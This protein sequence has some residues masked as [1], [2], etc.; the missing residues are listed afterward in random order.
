MPA[1]LEML[2]E[3]ILDGARRAQQSGAL[4]TFDLP[5]D[6]PINRPKRP[7]WGDFSSALALQLAASAHKKPLEIAQTIQQNLPSVEFID[8][9]SVSPPGFL[10]LVLSKSWLKSQVEVILQAGA[11]YA[12]IPRGGGEKAQVEFVSANP[13]GPLS[14]GRGRGA[15][16]GDTMANLLEAAGYQVTR[17]YYFNN[18]GKQMH[19][20]GESL[21]LR[22]L[23]VLGRE[24]EF[25]EGLYQGAYLVDLANELVSKHGRALADEGW[26]YFKDVAEAAMFEN[27]Q[28]TLERLNIEMDVFFN[29]NSLYEDG[30]VWEVL[31]LMRQKGYIYERDGAT[32]FQATRLGGP[33]DRVMVRSNGEP[34]YRLPDIAYHRNKLERGFSLVLDVL[35]A[36]HKDAFPD[37]VRGVSVLGYEA[38]KIDVLFN[39]FVTVRGERMSTR[40]GHFTLLDELIDEVGADVVRFFMLMRSADSHLEFDLDLA[41]EQSEKNPVYYVQY[42]HTRICSILS[43]AQE[44]GFSGDSGDVTL[45]D[46][47]SEK[48]LI[49]ELLNLS[50][51]IAQSI[52]EK[53][54][55]LLST[56][57]R[58][59]AS[60]FHAFYRDCLVLD[61]NQPQLSRARLM[62]VRAARI[63]LARSL[64]LLGV[65]APES[66]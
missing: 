55:H 49:L 65:S 62:L 40:A 44:R 28:A 51:I 6:A 38:S 41:L 45:L 59:L 10:N 39:Q 58:D 54:P 36:D 9:S 52:D 11:H 24:V 16:I 4:P 29:E 23:Q 43:K 57:A 20:L 14:V 66:M 31:D 30:S 25:P 5:E 50:D 2:S 56:Y 18:A 7:E 21:R 33:E 8:S 13:T 42:A 12:D 19:D 35:G 22:Y 53:A 37:V 48:A 34:T 26:E 61:E 46:H 64:D 3:F 60:V 27:I 1:L 63:G 15:V 17:E 32:W 47:P